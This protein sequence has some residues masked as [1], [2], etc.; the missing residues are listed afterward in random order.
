MA[1]HNNVKDDKYNVFSTDIMTMESDFWLMALPED[2]R[3]VKA[4]KGLVRFV[5]RL[6]LLRH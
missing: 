6:I 5:V 2:F 1:N 4:K 3:E